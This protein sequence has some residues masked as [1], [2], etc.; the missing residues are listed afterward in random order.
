MNGCEQLLNIVNKTGKAFDWN[1]IL[2]GASAT[3]FETGTA[4]VN[5]RTITITK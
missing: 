1:S 5:G 2:G 3:S 4:E